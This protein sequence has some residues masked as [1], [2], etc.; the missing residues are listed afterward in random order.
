MTTTRTVKYHVPQQGLYVY[1][2]TVDGKTELIVLNSTDIEQVLPNNHF[3]ALINESVE[4]KEI[5]SGKKIDLRENI[6]VPARKSV[7]IE[8]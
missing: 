4:G 6:V 5:S 1:S 2:R 3:K 7:I 8:C